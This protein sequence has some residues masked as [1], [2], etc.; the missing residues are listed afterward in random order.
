MPV[1]VLMEATLLG[2]HVYYYW[3]G[4]GC[5]SMCKYACP[6]LVYACSRGGQKSVLGVSLYHFIVFNFETV[7]LDEPR[8][9]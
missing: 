1:A 3:R 2:C 7:S 4:L 5:A 8:A 6:I 9:H